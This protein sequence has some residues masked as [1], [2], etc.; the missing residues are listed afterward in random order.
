[1]SKRATIW[2]MADNRSGV[3]PLP[4]PRNPAPMVGP[5]LTLIPLED[6]DRALDAVL[7]D[8]VRSPE[9]AAWW[10]EP[11][12]EFKDW[13]LG[14][15]VERR[16][17]ITLGEDR[18]PVGMI[19]WWSMDNEHYE[20]AGIDLFIS[21]AVHGVGLGREAVYLMARRL[22]DQ[23]HHRLAIDPAAA[24]TRAIRCYESVGFRKVGRMRGYEWSADN[25]G[26]QDGMLMDCLPGDLMRP[27]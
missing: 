19:S 11:A 15:D 6:I 10:S 25:S 12:Q 5:R 7:W 26:W 3:P 18:T 9:V 27:W 23:G 14:E 8:I 16:Y 4:F 21:G 13:P 24:N 20:H 1:M 22:F 17:A 2:P